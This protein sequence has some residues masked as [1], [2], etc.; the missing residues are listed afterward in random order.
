MTPKY[1]K[2]TANSVQDLFNN[3]STELQLD[4]FWTLKR[5]GGE[6]SMRSDSLSLRYQ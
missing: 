4:T 6:K 5:K 1:T 2:D 3:G